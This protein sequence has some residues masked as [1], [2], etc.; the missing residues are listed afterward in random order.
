MCAA[1]VSALNLSQNGID[2][3]GGIGVAYR[4]ANDVKFLAGIAC[5][6]TAPRQVQSLADPFRNGHVA[7]ARHPLNFAVVG[8]L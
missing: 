5:R 8:V 4:R 3:S 6:F 1:A 2:V 7:R